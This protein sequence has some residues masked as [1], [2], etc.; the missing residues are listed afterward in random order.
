MLKRGEINPKIGCTDGHLRSQIRSALRKVWRNSARR[1][2]LETVRFPYEGKTGRGKWGVECVECG[3][4]MGYSEKEFRTKKD[5][6]PT[7]QKKLVYEVNHI[8]DGNHSFLDIKN[9][10]GMF[11]YDLLY[12]E[13]EILCWKCHGKETK[14]QTNKRKDG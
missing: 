6:T 10:L 8:G 5:G 9:D 2:F 7:K 12:G 13:Q 1:V 4:K 14:R 3:R 11:A